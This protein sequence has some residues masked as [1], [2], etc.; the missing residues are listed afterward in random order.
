MPAGR[1]Q[2]TP[3]ILPAGGEIMRRDWLAILEVD[4]Q[5]LGCGRWLTVPG[6]V[7][8][9]EEIAAQIVGHAVCREKGESEWRG[10]GLD[11]DRRRGNA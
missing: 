7:L 5:Q 6:T 9:N 8:D 2:R 1:P 4:E 3:L 11:A 10:V